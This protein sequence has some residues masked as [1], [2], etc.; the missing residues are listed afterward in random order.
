MPNSTNSCSLEYLADFEIT[1]LLK[2]LLG[3]QLICT[4]IS[5]NTTLISKKA[6]KV[7]NQK[8]TMHHG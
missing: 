8:V 1:E 3:L 5:P 7:H 4:L 6:S 2:L